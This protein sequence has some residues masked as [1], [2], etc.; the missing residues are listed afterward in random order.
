[1][2]RVL[3]AMLGPK[4]FFG[5]ESA[6][7]RMAGDLSNRLADA[8]SKTS[9]ETRQC[10]EKPIFI[11][12]AGWRS[13]STLLQR[14]LMKHN[15]SII[16]WGEPFDHANI[17][18]N[19]ANQF[20]CFTQQWPP[21]RF[22]ISN[23]S[24]QAKLSDEWIA[25][26]YPAVDCFVRAHRQFFDCLFGEPARAL[27]KS[28]WGLKE[29]RLNIDHARYFRALYPKCKILLLCRNPRD[30]YASYRNLGA[31]WFRSWPDRAV[32][33]PF[34]FGRQWAEM[35][36]GFIDECGEIDALLVRYEDL[37]NATDVNRI[38]KY[39]GWR[40]SRSSDLLHRDMVNARSSKRELPR[41]DRVLL[42][43]G[44]GQT[45]REMGYY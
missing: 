29:V 21:D 36:R 43:I 13:G 23:V 8:F 26:L 44:T 6:S 10:E 27:G 35:T 17:Y 28:E 31:A 4:G 22:F 2:K 16:I 42:E 5:L 19:M 39:L 33:T 1:M 3:R 40:V 41:I 12:S 34:E 30:A 38:E 14:M 9:V 32:K 18:G 7:R 11:L 20:R 25:N 37:S 45:R 24:P 15:E